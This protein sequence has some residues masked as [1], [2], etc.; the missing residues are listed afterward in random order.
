MT[1]TVCKNNKMTDFS[2]PFKD[3]SK[4]K[5]RLF[6]QVSLFNFNKGLIGCIFDGKYRS[7]SRIILCACNITYI[8]CKSMDYITHDPFNIDLHL[9][10]SY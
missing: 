2:C 6:F 9:E 3:V 8:N 1:S 4:F 10:Y 7:T 5:I